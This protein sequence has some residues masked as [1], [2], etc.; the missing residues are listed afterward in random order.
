MCPQRAALSGRAASRA[1]NW[2]PTPQCQGFPLDP[3]APHGDWSNGCSEGA[4]RGGFSAICG[5]PFEIEMDP[6]EVTLT[7]PTTGAQAALRVDVQERVED[8]LPTLE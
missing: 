8:R 7:M 3:G 1:D 4:P 5:D 2:Q 6:P